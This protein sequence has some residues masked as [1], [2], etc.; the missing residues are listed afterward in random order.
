MPDDISSANESKVLRDLHDLI[1]HKLDS[2][3]LAKKRGKLTRRKL[4]ECDDWVDWETS[5]HKQLDQYDAQ[6]TFGPPQSLPKDA[7]V[8]NLL[9]TY[10]IKDDGRKK[11]RCVCNGSKNMRGSV[12]LAETYAAA[13]EQTG[14][15]IFWAATAINNFICIGADAANAF[16]EAPA[17]VAPLYVRVDDQF[18]EWYTH[19]YPDKPPIPKGHVMRVLKALQGH[20]ESARLWALLIDKVIQQLNLKPCTHEP[21]L[22]YTTDYK[23]T[24]KT[25]L[26]LRQVD[27]FAISCQDKDTARDVIESINNEMTIDVKELGMISRFNGVDILQSRNFI[28]LSNETYLRKIFLHH[29]WLRDEHPLTKN[30]PIPMS[31][32]ATYQ[33]KLEEAEPL[34]PE[35]LEI[36]EK[37][38]GFTYR[39]A[40]GELIYALVTCRPDIS[41]ACIK[42]SQFSARPAKIHFDA[43]KH[44]YKYLLATIDRGINF[45]RRTPNMNLPLVDEPK[46]ELDANYD[47]G[48]SEERLQTDEKRMFGAV[49]SDY[50]GDNSHRKSVSGIAIKLAICFMC[51]F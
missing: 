38:M 27:D 44:V 15:R 17:P 23:G 43:V 32:S 33:R 42:L 16:A 5:E 40:I 26:F 39:Q 8:L 36:I 34:S 11:A 29:L 18:R 35:E 47:E 13:L 21:N 50:A 48:A 25:V 19:R 20:P 41:F 45:W 49:D 30:K 22:Y 37:E 2:T 6:D 24:G 31:D 9:W 14:S 28:R 12:T 7:N 1:V 51:N 3:E 10:L 46:P 4:M